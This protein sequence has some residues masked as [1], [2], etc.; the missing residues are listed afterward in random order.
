[1]AALYAVLLLWYYLCLPARLFD[2][3]YS[4]V[5]FD[6]EGRLLGAKIAADGQ[7]RFP[8]VDSV[9]H[10]FATAL[11]AFEDKRFRS[12]WGVDMRALTRAIWQNTSK[13][14]KVSGASTISMQVI[15]LHRQNPPRTLLEK[16]KEMILATRL[17][18]SYSKDEILR[19]YATHAPF[20]GNVVG[21]ETAAWKYFARPAAN[22]S[23]AESCMLAV[24]PNSPSL[25]HIS[26]NR[27]ALKDKRDRLLDRLQAQG[28]IDSLTCELSKIEPLPE[29]PPALPNL[30]P[31][32]LERVYADNLRQKS[33]SLSICRSS[34][35]ANL[36]GNI[37]DILRRHYAP[38]SAN[39]IHNAAVLVID[40]QSA[41][42]LAYVGN[43]P[44]VDEAHS[45]AVDITQ[46]P[47]SS[48]SILKPFLYAAML[49]D[50]E[51]CP[52]TLFP[53]IPTHFK[54]YTPKNYD[55]TY[56]GA[57]PASVMIARSLNVPAIYMLHQ[58]GAVRLLHKLR[59]LGMSTLTQSADHYGLTLILGGAE[60]KLWDLA[61]MYTGM[62][63]ALNNF[64][65]YDGKYDRDDYKPVS[66]LL[67]HSRVPTTALNLQRLHANPPLR[68]SAIWHTFQ[69]MQEV[70]RPGDEHHWRAF[71]SSHRVAWKTGTSFGFRDAWA[72]GCTPR[73]V[74]AVWVGNANGEGRPGL[75]GVRAA[76]PVL[77][78]VFNV[79]AGNTRQWF[80]PP[81]DDMRLQAVCRHSGQRKG[82]FCPDVDSLWLPV[83]ATATPLCGYHQRVFLSP[84]GQFR[85][86]SDCASP[87]N[88]LA[89]T[90]FILPAAQEWFYKRQ[91]LIESPPPWH[92]DC[93]PSA[94]TQKGELAF[95][96]PPQNDL[97]IYIPREL[98][99]E[100]SRVVFE[101]ASKRRVGNIFWHL[102][103]EYIGTTF[104]I[105]QLALNPPVGKHTI[106][107]VDEEGESISRRFE[108]V[109]GGK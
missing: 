32:L 63:R 77:F 37:N 92:A 74:V 86:N 51:M 67:A 98:S 70:A 4:T 13:A 10:K 97:K 2:V 46:A 62:S 94:S 84:D 61:T 19:M 26:R 79:L 96:Y 11:L 57:A 60:C 80:A 24:L 35:D 66:Y 20:G 39:G 82:E 16:G 58:Y 48:G 3:P 28:S 105:H 99:E 73:Y 1:M 72:V 14:T 108:V 54:G 103:D 101:V 90:F 31:H 33:D 81:Y 34:I 83:S 29:V 93:Q 75:L 64:A 109:V 87:Q 76:A 38:L 50:G 17:E 91:H 106:T 12:H 65:R 89:D 52:N 56:S 47:R 53:D 107:A 36:Q 9:P 6:R 100:Q 21:L 69:S 104:E 102:D 25:I 40:V 22:L 27:Q 45:P 44:D 30:A 88:M 41:T 95:L 5:L 85:V 18:W 59:D 43:M 68:A 71:Q 55:A 15:R 78:D 42:C 7:W 23:W 49:H 8:P